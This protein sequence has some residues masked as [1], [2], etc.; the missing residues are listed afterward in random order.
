MN[1]SYDV[2]VDALYIKLS[3]SHELLETRHLDDDIAIN[4]DES[5]C[6]VGI[7]VLN[8]SKRTDLR[9][10]YPVD[11][12]LA[13]RTSK[14]ASQGASSRRNGFQWHTLRDNLLR[15]KDARIPIETRHRRWKNWI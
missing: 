8:A 13:T 3:P 9:H 1:I 14:N 2:K 11:V 15:L 6:L 5:G 4:I 7:E 10:I 12:G